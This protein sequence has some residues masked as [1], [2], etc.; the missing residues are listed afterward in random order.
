MKSCKTESTH[1]A[2]EISSFNFGHHIKQ[3]VSCI[4]SL[5]LSC[6]QGGEFLHAQR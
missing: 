5:Q 2:T 4:L 3:L 6:I 1:S